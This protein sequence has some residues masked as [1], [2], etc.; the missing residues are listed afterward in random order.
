MIRGSIVGLLAAALIPATA[1]ATA[2]AAPPPDVETVPDEYLV[3]LDHVEA[4]A[5]ATGGTVEVLGLGW[6]LLRV[7]PGTEA[8]LALAA[9]VDLYPN[10]VLLPQEEPLQDAQWGLAKIR[11]T[12]AW[13]VTKG[14][15]AI[16]V[17]VLDTGTDLEHPELEPRLWDNPGEVPGN[18]SDDDHNGFVDDAHGWDFSDD[19]GRPDDHGYHGT[20]M[21]GILA[22]AIDGQGVA[23]V[24]PGIRLMPVRVCDEICPDDDVIAGLAYAVAN[25]ADVINISL[26]R[27]PLGADLDAPLRQAVKAA[28]KAGVLVVAAAGNQATDADVNPLVP[29]AFPGNTIVSVAATDPSDL[30]ASFSNWGAETVDL[31]APGTNILSTTP[32]DYDAAPGHGSLSGTSPATPHVTA[33]AALIRSANPCSPPSV[34]RSTILGTVD[35][36]PDLEGRTVSGGRLDAGAAV[37]ASLNRYGGE[38]DIEASASPAHGGAPLAVEL[39]GDAKCDPTG[40]LAGYRW[41]FGDGGAADGSTVVHVFEEPGVYTAR[42]TVRAPVGTEGRATVPVIVGLPFQD[43]NGSIFAKEIAW[44]SAKGITLGCDDA[45]TLFCPQAGVRRGQMA[46][47]LVRAL[48]LPAGPDAFGDDDGTTHED[49]INALAATGITEGCTATSFCADEEVTRGQMASF[50]VRALDLP[51]GPDAFGDDDGTTHEDAINALAATGI[52][53]GCTSTTFCPQM[54]VTRGQMAAFL[55][56]ALG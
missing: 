27:A 54:E 10:P 23:G 3:P 6:A 1:S 14:R 36:A 20:I 55:Y 11:T 24:A 48:D 49:A 37:N 13:E 17:A 53:Q 35:A 28:G 51:A 32:L 41:T 5:A 7:D 30:L 15:P 25:G 19:D 44:L 8:D 33:A 22:A 26:G 12:A 2:S 34:V 42:V 9:G 18:G 4:A 29:A 45:G 39:T 40:K 46:S 31:G 52:T 47:F 21:S 43:L 16:V 56:R 38:M 50:L